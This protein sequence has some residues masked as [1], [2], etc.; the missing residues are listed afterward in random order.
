[1]SDDPEDWTPRERALLDALEG[2]PPPSPELEARVVSELK[3]RGLI[4]SRPSRLPWRPAAAALVA[5]AA[6]VGLGRMTSPGL[7]ASSP[8][9]RTFLL[10]L[11]PG[12]GLDP[13]PAAERARVEEYGRWARGLAREGRMIRGEKLKDGARVLG[14]DAP[15][16]SSLQGFFLIRAGTPE[17]AEAIAHAC[18]HRGHGGTIAVREVDPT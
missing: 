11:Y 18:P 7:P 5:L 4:G 17:E 8:P 16:A 2:T 13:S 9:A 15:D 3:A 10:L 14:S 1:M 6:G 12:A